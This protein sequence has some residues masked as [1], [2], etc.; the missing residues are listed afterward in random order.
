MN[1]S[2][3]FT[4]SSVFERFT[5]SNPSYSKL[6]IPAGSAKSQ[7]FVPQRNCP[8]IFMDEIK[9]Y[10]TAPVRLE[11]AYFDSEQNARLIFHAQY[12]KVEGRN[13]VHIYD[14]AHFVPINLIGVP[15][16]V[17]DLLGYRFAEID[18]ALSVA[19]A[20]LEIDTDMH[21]EMMTLTH[22][23]ARGLD[24]ALISKATPVVAK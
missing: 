21:A 11:V 20:D 17:K 12:Q 1:V 9:L 2:G 18:S 16:V 4:R 13:I 24:S 3:R 6:S 10:E 14:G 15:K 8:G 23:V 7:T 22:F 19:V 5:D